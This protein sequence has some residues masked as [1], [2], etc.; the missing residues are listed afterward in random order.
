VTEDGVARDDEA[1]PLVDDHRDHMVEV[2]ILVA[3]TS[4]D[5]NKQLQAQDR[6]EQLYAALSHP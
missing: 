2:R 3:Q 4:G 6:L 1:I 5:K